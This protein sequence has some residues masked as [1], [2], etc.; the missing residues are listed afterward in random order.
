M[1]TTDNSAPE[2]K[3]GDIAKATETVK[4]AADEV[5][6]GDITGGEKQKDADMVPLAAFL[7]EKNARKELTKEVQRLT[8]AIGAGATDKE[9]SQSIDSVAEEF[10]LDKAALN[11]LARAIRVETEAA[12]EEK[13]SKRLK[14]F[15][16]SAR[17][18]AVRKAFTAHYDKALENMEDFKG[19]VNKDVIFRLTVDPANANKTISEII[20]DTYGSALGGKRTVDSANSSRGTDASAILDK[21]RMNT[22]EKYLDEVLAN[23][24]LKKQYDDALLEYMKR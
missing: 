6:A 14:P 3:A 13:F 17:A 8:A 16:D 19:I 11:K 22:D 23:P 5:K 20:E 24:I 21:A 9:V 10:G 12:A 7:E 4:P 2:A 1:S 18:E 15:E